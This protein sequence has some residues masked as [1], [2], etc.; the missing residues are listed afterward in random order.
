[1]N[2]VPDYKAMAFHYVRRLCET[3]ETL[4]GSWVGDPIVLDH[5]NGEFYCFVNVAVEYAPSNPKGCFR[6]GRALRV[7]ETDMRF[8]AFCLCVTV[9]ELMLLRGLRHNKHFVVT[10][11]E[12]NAIETALRYGSA[13]TWSYGV[14]LLEGLVR[15]GL[16][17]RQDAERY[18]IAPWLFA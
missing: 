14:A 9:S 4:A 6:E 13:T 11:T 10:R 16:L 15:A 5:G 7:V 8:G 17:L 3:H 2:T 12:R 1:M 18:T